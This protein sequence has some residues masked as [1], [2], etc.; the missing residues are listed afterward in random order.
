MR[1]ACR[2]V[3]ELS[4]VIQ[5]WKD[6]YIYLLQSCV[7]I[8]SADTVDYCQMKLFGGDAVS[9]SHCCCC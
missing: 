3:G 8:P 4:A 2:E 7:S 5:A 6:D 1:L 9:L